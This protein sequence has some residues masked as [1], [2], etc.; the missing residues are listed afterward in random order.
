MKSLYRMYCLFWVTT[1][2]FQVTYFFV[3]D[4]SHWY[5]TIGLFCMWLT[6]LLFAHLI[7]RGL[8]KEREILAAQH[9]KLIEE[10]KAQH[11]QDREAYQTINKTV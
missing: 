3:D 1:S 2:T 8:K 7:T 11:E 6:L 4:F 9:V 10:I 5:S